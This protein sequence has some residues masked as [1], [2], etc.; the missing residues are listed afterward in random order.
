MLRGYET[1]AN[2][3]VGISA[4]PA[5]K[6]ST[7][8]SRF[9]LGARADDTSARGDPREAIEAE[10]GGF[11][12]GLLGNSALPSGAEA[13]RAFYDYAAAQAQARARAEALRAASMAMPAPNETDTAA[14]ARRFPRRAQMDPMT[15]ASKARNPIGEIFLAEASARI[16]RRL[17]GAGRLCRA[18]RRLLV[19]SF[20]R[21]GR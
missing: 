9:G 18:A 2:R 10:L 17:R 12:A 15:M 3:E 8:L 11:G 5:V 13:L 6:W 16:A 1:T 19:E 20:L 14:D 4:R 21:L 7:A